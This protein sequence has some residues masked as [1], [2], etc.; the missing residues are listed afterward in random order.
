[1]TFA[2]AVEAALAGMGKAE[3]VRAAVEPAVAELVTA[4]A[5]LAKS[6]D[7]DVTALLNG[8]P[9]HDRTVLAGAALQGELQSSLDWDAI[10]AAVFSSAWTVLRAASAVAAI[11]G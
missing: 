1:M 8:D 5:E 3:L 9:V 4:A 6:R 11:F 7:V 10:P 2:E